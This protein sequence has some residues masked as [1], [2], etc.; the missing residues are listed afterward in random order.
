M[1]NKIVVVGSGVVGTATGQGF[2]RTG[3]QVT[4]VDISTERVEALR[5]AGFDAT[6]ELDLTGEGAFVFLTL[7][8]PHHGRGYDLTPFKAGVASVGAALGRAAATSPSTYNTI[9]VRSTVPPGTCQEVVGPL[10]EETSGLWVGDGF[11]LASAPEFLRATSALEDFLSP[12]MTVIAARSRRTVE[13]LEELFRPFGGE[14]RT[15]SNPAVAEMI[16]CTHNVYNASKISFWNEVWNVCENLH[17]PAEDVATT[18]ARSAEGSINPNYG[19]HGGRPYGGACLPK[20]V[21]GYLG[22]ADRLGID[23]PMIESV[24]VVNQRIADM[25][26]GGVIDLTPLGLP[27]QRSAV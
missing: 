5:A 27:T 9:I 18:V 4:F 21:A 19:I 10:L 15:F 1:M 8:T 22:L 26:S 25:V 7:P 17:I 24:A 20:D 11:A 3:H 14:V 2:L 12:W 23:V 16:K 6:T 13:R